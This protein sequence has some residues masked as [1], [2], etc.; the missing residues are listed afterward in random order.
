MDSMH[1]GQQVT[2]VW[3]NGGFSDKLNSS[4]SNQVL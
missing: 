2:S 3:R 4:F 1:K